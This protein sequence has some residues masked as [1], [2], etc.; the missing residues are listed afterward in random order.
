MTATPRVN[1]EEVIPVPSGRPKSAFL[2]PILA[3]VWKDILLE[4]R[5]KAI[6]LSLVMF[7]ILTVVVFNFALDPTS[8]A[9]D[10][11]ISGILWVAYAFAGVLGMARIFVLERDGGS[12]EGL[13][14][15]PVSRDVIYFGKFSS[16]LIFMLAAEIGVLFLFSILFNLPLLLPRL[17]LVALLASLGFAAVGTLFSA[18]SVN[19]RSRDVMLPLGYGAVLRSISSWA[20][21]RRHA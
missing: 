19:T 15:S 4:V 14:L 6:L 10:G 9:D 11:V 8:Q 1:S 7:A 20:A 2:A 5:S 13:V 16:L 3:I 21:R 18:M 12:L 17:W